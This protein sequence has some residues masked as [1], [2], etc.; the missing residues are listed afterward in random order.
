M[1]AKES[2]VAISEAVR[3]ASCAAE[4]RRAKDENRRTATVE[5]TKTLTC[6]TRAIG[7]YSKKCLDC[8]E[9]IFSTDFLY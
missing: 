9:G 7:G 5:S 1:G 6:W 3:S 8:L 4:L 2:A